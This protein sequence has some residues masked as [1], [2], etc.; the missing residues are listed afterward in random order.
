MTSA[1]PLRGGSYLAGSAPSHL[2]NCTWAQCAPEKAI[3]DEVD[4][5][6]L[7]GAADSDVMTANSTRQP[8]VALPG[9]K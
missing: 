8:W 5:A 2:C 7:E 9:F 4:V 1:L 6:D 3:I